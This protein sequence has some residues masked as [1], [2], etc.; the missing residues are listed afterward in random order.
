MLHKVVLHLERHE[1]ELALQ[2]LAAVELLAAEQRLAFI[3]SPEVFRGGA[4]L[5]QGA[6]RDALAML[7]AGL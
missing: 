4:L 3:H 1:P 5:L 6:L 2:E 7:R